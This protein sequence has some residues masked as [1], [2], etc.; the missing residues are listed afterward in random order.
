M[1]YVGT[2]VSD[3]SVSPLTVTPSPDILALK[4]QQVAAKTA[5]T[6]GES[7]LL[8][9][10]R[11]QKDNSNR[12]KPEQEKKDGVG[13]ERANSAMAAAAPRA[14]PPSK[15][16]SVTSGPSVM[17]TANQSQPNPNNQAFKRSKHRCL[18]KFRIKT[19]YTYQKD[20]GV[21]WWLWAFPLQ[22][23]DQRRLS[24]GIPLCRGWAAT[25]AEKLWGHSGQWRLLF[26]LIKIHFPFRKCVLFHK[27]ECILYSSSNSAL[28][29][30][31][32]VAISKE[33]SCSFRMLTVRTIGR[34]WPRN[35][36]Q[37]GMRNNY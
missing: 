17:T 5:P 18:W 36:I 12:G 26:L 22:G 28:V 30:K 21:C 27:I 29:I 15:D 2:V 8:R 10:A 23:S 19:Q 9:K 14:K 32:L 3:T 24:T 6:S 35:Q 31:K 20:R 13:N 4:L 7:R 11:E 1:D 25:S 16:V 33:V 37:A 34:N